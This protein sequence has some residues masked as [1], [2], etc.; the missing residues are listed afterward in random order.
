MG[1]RQALNYPGSGDYFLGLNV[2]QRDTL[3]IPVRPVL[4]NLSWF[5]SSANIAIHIFLL[6]FHL[7]MVKRHWG[8]NSGYKFSSYYLNHGAYLITVNPYS[9][10]RL[11]Y[12]NMWGSL[13]ALASDECR[14]YSSRDLDYDI[15]LCPRGSGR[16]Q[17][18]GITWA[19]SSSSRAFLVE[20]R[21]Y[22]NI[23]W[24]NEH[25]MKKGT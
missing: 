6:I 17:G 18:G 9:L 4:Q 19:H 25:Q 22:A 11:I 20:G 21:A 15:E 13:I 7:F 24:I 5:L 10:T 14:K 8:K 3:L 23:M 12:E 16:L 1:C 2:I